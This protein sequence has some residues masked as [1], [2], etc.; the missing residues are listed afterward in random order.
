M[1]FR[2]K[3]Q[4]FQRRIIFVLKADEVITQN[5]KAVTKLK[6]VNGVLTNGED[7][8][9]VLSSRTEDEDEDEN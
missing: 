5:V 2:Y 6:F 4:I 1:D 3:V 9:D 7:P 8:N